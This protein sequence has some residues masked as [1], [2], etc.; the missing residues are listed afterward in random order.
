[1][2]KNIHQKVI[3]MVSHFKPNSFMSSSFSPLKFPLEWKHEMPSCYL[4]SAKSVATGKL[5]SPLDTVSHGKRHPIE[6]QQYNERGE[7]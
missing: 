5:K 1:M 3:E 7:I 2:N 6:I 4:F